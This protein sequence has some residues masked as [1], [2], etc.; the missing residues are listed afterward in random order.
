[1]DD[2]EDLDDAD[3]EDDPDETELDEQLERINAIVESAASEGFDQALGKFLEHLKSH[4]QMPCEVK[5][6]EDFQWEERYVI[7]GW[8]QQE[9]KQLKKT[10]PSYT[11]RYQLISIE[12][13]VYS[14]WM[15]CNGEDI[16]ARVLRIRDGKRFVL[17]LSE[18]KATDKKSP[19]FQL[20]DDYASFFWNNR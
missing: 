12:L 9:Y 15:M 17:G 19:N 20:L 1:M 3:D 10:Q 16:A 7:G 13:D 8:S 18:L 11:D 2:V 6:T 4:L 14:P 5:G